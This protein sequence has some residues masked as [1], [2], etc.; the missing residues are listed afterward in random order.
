MK[1]QNLEEIGKALL[2]DLK[3][4]LELTPDNQWLEQ[5]FSL[6]QTWI[7]QV[8]DQS[9]FY[10]LYHDIHSL[11][12]TIDNDQHFTENRYPGTIDNPDGATECTPESSFMP[13][14]P[15]ST[16]NDAAYPGRPYNA[17]SGESENHGVHEKENKAQGITKGE[18]F[19]GQLARTID[20]D[21]ATNLSR[22]KDQKN[23]TK[24]SDFQAMASDLV[25]NF[26]PETAQTAANGPDTGNAS[27]PTQQHSSRMHP[28]NTEADSTRSVHLVKDNRKQSRTSQHAPIHKG[29]SNSPVLAH[30]EHRKH[31]FE[32]QQEEFTEKTHQSEKP[33]DLDRFQDMA[34]HLDRHFNPDQLP[35][36]LTNNQQKEETP[37]I[38]DPRN[39]NASL[40]TMPATSTS[41]Q[42]VATEKFLQAT[43]T[44]LG[45]RHH[46][47]TNLPGME[48][49]DKTYDGPTH[50]SLSVPQANIPHP[51]SSEATGGWK[52][53]DENRGASTIKKNTENVEG[54]SEQAKSHEI[55]AALRKQPT[56]SINSPLKP[57]G[58]RLNP[59]SSTRN[60]SPGTG[61][62][63]TYDPSNEKLTGSAEQMVRQMKV[64][65][66]S[67]SPEELTI[68]MQELNITD[69][70]QKTTGPSIEIAQ[71]KETRP[72]E[73]FSQKAQG[74]KDP[75]DEIAF[76]S[77]ENRFITEPAI[78]GM[79][80]R[81]ELAKRTIGYKQSKDL[82]KAFNRYYRQ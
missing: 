41:S 45:H 65:M 21:V 11:K 74:K 12:G 29:T 26:N 31:N 81:P 68:W 82:T 37:S 34:H 28:A 33:T 80:H 40:N 67:L 46:Q 4:L 55:G 54:T 44:F 43:E 24:H 61:P 6:T 75:V 2:K 78:P 47:E 56:D 72:P 76:S 23:A 9:A 18:V 35:Q 25:K 48:Q 38:A 36:A 79:W 27:H 77:S 16:P 62:L 32:N 3:S 42:E 50:R 51:P 59:L 30:S 13:N 10:Q 53:Q 14:A 5:G 71:E 57:G 70:K 22:E 17:G 60:V 1:D 66:E 8:Q 64:L 39:E 63:N 19:G 49:T 52:A 7:S 69:I 20:E 15:E 73:P 58:T